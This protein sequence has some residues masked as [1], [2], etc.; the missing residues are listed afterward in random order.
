MNEWPPRTLGSCYPPCP[1][2][3]LAVVNNQFGPARSLGGWVFREGPERRLNEA[4]KWK[5]AYFGQE[6]EDHSHEPYVHT[7][8]PFCG[9]DLA[10]PPDDEGIE[11]TDDGR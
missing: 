10:P 5:A 3:L 9:R 1:E 6:I 2:R 8:C 11:E 7:C 4:A